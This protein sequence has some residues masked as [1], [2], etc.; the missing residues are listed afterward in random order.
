MRVSESGSEGEVRGKTDGENEG[1]AKVEKIC[2]EQM[3][4][5]RKHLVSASGSFCHFCPCVVSIFL[6][7]TECVGAESV[8][9]PGTF[10]WNR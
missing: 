1:K 6:Y 10:I 5:C 3:D 7:R 9:I 2:E 4:C 8:C